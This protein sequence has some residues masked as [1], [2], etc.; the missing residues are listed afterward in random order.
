MEHIGYIGVIEELEK[1]VYR[2]YIY[3]YTC[4]YMSSMGVIIRGVRTRS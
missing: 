2:V 3:I 4:G 1:G